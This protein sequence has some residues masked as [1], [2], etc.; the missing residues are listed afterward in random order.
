MGSACE[1][2][3][4][5]QAMVRGDSFENLCKIAEYYDYLEIQPL[6]NNM[7]MV[8][9][10][11]TDIEGLKEYNRTI[12]RIGEKLHK[13]VVATCDVHFKEPE[14]A[15]FRKILMASKGFKDADNQAP[16]YFRTTNEMLEEFAYLGPEL[17][18][19]VV[20]DNPVRI[21]EMVEK[22]LPIPDGQFSPVIVGVYFYLSVGVLG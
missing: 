6:G 10:G 12:V 20:I 5:F 11:D 1:A 8:R 21:S 18:H 15:V 3:E 4:L 13:M 9:N 14:D 16:L 7:F 19:Q 17:C 22:I 2:G